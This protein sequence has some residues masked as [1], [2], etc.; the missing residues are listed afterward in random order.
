MTCCSPWENRSPKTEMAR[1]STILFDIVPRLWMSGNNEELGRNLQYLEKFIAYQDDVVNRELEFAEK[2]RPGITQ[3]LSMSALNSSFNLEQ[4]V[5]LARS[6]VHAVN[7]RNRFIRG[8]SE[9]VTRLALQT[10]RDMN[11]SASDLEYLELA[12]L[13]HDVGKLAIPEAVLSKVQ[14]LTP[15]ER[16]LIQKHPFYGANIVK[17]VAGL[18][19]IVPWISTTRSVG[20]ARDTR[21]TF[22]EGYPHGRQHHR[23]C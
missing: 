8:H 15:D 16:T 18:N 22:P 23:G 17:P 5:V 2:R 12:G 20:T 21:T 4:I 1:A 13:L 19:R 14:P 7:S 10:A 9:E 3:A 11:W 6:L